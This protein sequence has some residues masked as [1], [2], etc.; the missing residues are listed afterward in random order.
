MSKQGTTAFVAM[1]EALKEFDVIVTCGEV[2]VVAE[3]DKSNEGGDFAGARKADESPATNLEEETSPAREKADESSATNLE[4][5]RTYEHTADK[6]SSLTTITKSTPMS[7]PEAA[8]WIEPKAGEGVHYEVE[9]DE[10]GF[11]W[12]YCG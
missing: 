5:N 1:C 12:R 10:E 2:P 7:A 8:T 9:R 4:T 11:S 6:Q 3:E